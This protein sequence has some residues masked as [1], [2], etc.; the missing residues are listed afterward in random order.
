MNIL[1][2]TRK[3]DA[4][5]VEY[6]AYLSI[7]SPTVRIKFETI[8][9]DPANYYRYWLIASVVNWDDDVEHCSISYEVELSTTNRI[10]EKINALN[11]ISEVIR[12]YKQGLMGWFEELVAM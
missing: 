3:K 11:M 2:W 9:I 1:K 8:R 5:G 10:E 7:G 4:C 12:E 6:Y